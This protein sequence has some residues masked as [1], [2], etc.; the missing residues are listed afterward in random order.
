LAWSETTNLV[1][2]H[3]VYGSLIGSIGLFAAA[4]SDGAAT[5]AIVTLAFTIGS[6]VLDFAVAGRPGV[7]E[8]L[9]HLSLTQV[10]RPFEQGLFSTGVLGG[11]VVV[12]LAFAALAGIWLPP[13]VPARTKFASSGACVATS[14][15]L[16]FLASQIG[17]SVDVSEDR[18]NSFS[19]VDERALAL[20]V[21]PLMVS[22]HLAAED[23]R[24][25]DLH[26]N[27][28]AKLQRA[29]PHVAIRLVTNRRSFGSSGDDAYGEIEFTYGSR[30]D[31]TR[32]TS[33]G[34][35]LPLLYR[36]AEVDPPPPSR[37]P[38][39]RG[40]PLIS[41]GQTALAWYF[42]GLPLLVLLLWWLS[43]RRPSINYSVI[44]KEVMS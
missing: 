11:V 26:R 2:G 29:M 30:S 36:L 7:F 42:G 19:S 27:V 37:D 18:R 8:W 41:S 38:E 16:L 32:S 4:I 10:L 14:A 1:F 44:S 13:G 3:F 17:Y 24:Y 9:S 25:V 22:A 35:I 6:W 28:L 12:V 5:A 39:Y 34:E 31:R 23:P 21:D 15:A 20:L 40:Y 43:R 33:P